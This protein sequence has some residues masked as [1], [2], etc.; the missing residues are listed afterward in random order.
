[1][2]H[3]NNFF[4]LLFSSRTSKLTNFSISGAGPCL[5]WASLARSSSIVTWSIGGNSA[6]GF[7]LAPR[8]LTWSR[9]IIFGSGS[10]SSNCVNLNGNN[11]PSHSDFRKSHLPAGS[12]SFFWL[13]SGNCSASLAGDF[14]GNSRKAT[15]S[16]FSETGWY[17]DT[18]PA[19]NSTGSNSSPGNS[20]WGFST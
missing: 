7:G 15:V 8:N 16:N 12:P 4:S 3:L 11:F 14:S 10:G 19:F 18:F 5:G 13:Q 6:A 9:W 17:R 20:R 1:M 2:W